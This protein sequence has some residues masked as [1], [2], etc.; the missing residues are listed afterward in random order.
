MLLTFTRDDIT[1]S[2]ISKC[3]SDIIVSGLGRSIALCTRRCV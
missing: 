1:A 3:G 2:K